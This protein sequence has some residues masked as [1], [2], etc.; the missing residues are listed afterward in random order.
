MELIQLPQELLLLIA[1]S[2]EFLQEVNSL[3]QANRSLYHTLNSHLYEYNT[4]HHESDVLQ[5]AAIHSLVEVVKTALQH[6]A[7]VNTTAPIHGLKLPNRFASHFSQDLQFELQRN[8]KAKSLAQF[9]L[10]RGA[11]TPLVLAA[12]AGYKDIVLS[13][14]QHGAAID[15]TGTTGLTPLMVAAQGGHTSV[16]KLLLQKCAGL[17]VKRHGQYMTALE[18]AVEEGHAGVVDLLLQHGQD[19]NHPSLYPAL[20]TAAEK[21]HIHVVQMLLD[22]GADI[23]IKSSARMTALLHATEG[24]YPEVVRLL[25][26]HGEDFESCGF[27]GVT[28]LLHTTRTGSVKV[29]ELLLHLGAEANVTDENNRTPLWWAVDRGEMEMVEMLL[30][31]GARGGPE[32]NVLEMDQA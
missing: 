9:Y 5:W 7:D 10:C 32:D 27:D 19:P 23:Q 17:T 2:L 12:G 6:G 18:L 26:Q 3:C 20:T 4:R 15:R 22:H 30:K 1:D 14:L 25:V 11:V 8:N 24:E 31:H 29:C 16:V 28:L 13:L 21:G